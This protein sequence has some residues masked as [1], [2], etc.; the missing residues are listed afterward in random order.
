MASPATKDVLNSLAPVQKAFQKADGCPFT[1]QCLQHLIDH[2][3]SQDWAALQIDL[4]NA[5]NAVH[6]QAILDAV[7]Q[8][9]PH[10]YAWCLASLRPSSLNCSN[11]VLASTEGCQQGDPLGPLFFALAVQD[12]IE[13]LTPQ[14]SWQSWFLDDGVLFGPFAALES[15]WPSLVSALDARGGCVN[16]SKSRLWGPGCPDPPPASSPLHS[17]GHVPYTADS[18]IEVLG[19]PVHHPT[20]PAFSVAFCRSRIEQ[21]GKLSALVKMLPDPQLKHALT[22]HCLDACR[23]LHLQQTTAWAA[24][25]SLAAD[26]DLVIRDLASDFARSPLPQEAWDQASLPLK[27]GG[28]G[29]KLP[30]DKECY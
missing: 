1:A 24:H 17:I 20:S 5:F 7:A 28:L 12:V 15:L 21:L 6:R 29:I 10:L 19:H 14:V 18:G 22:R 16:T 26:A 2:A 8:R 9:A 11:F 23:L 25:P 4:S 30:S 3:A 13:T 27:L